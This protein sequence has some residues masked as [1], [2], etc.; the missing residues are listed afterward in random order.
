LGI[1]GIALSILFG[2]GVIGGGPFANLNSVP[3]TNWGPKG[4]DQLNMSTQNTSA[5]DY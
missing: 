4:T 1:A 3:N 5:V 2:L